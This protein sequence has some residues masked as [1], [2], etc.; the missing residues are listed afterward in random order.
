MCLKSWGFLKDEGFDGNR[1][2][3]EELDDNIRKDRGIR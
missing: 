1:D 3:G 2:D